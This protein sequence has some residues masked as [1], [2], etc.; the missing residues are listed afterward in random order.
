MSAAPALKLRVRRVEGAPVVS[1]RCAVLGGARLEERPGQALITGR[2]LSEGTRRSSWSEIAEQAE[3]RG[4]NLHSSGSYEAHGL[5]IDALAEDWSP[6]LD[7]LAELLLE[8]TFPEPRCEWLRRQAAAELESLG[9]Q[10]DVLTGWAFAKQLYAPHPRARPV[11]GT[12]SGLAALGAAECVAFHRAGLGR[13]L[14]ISAAGDL[15]EEAV[16]ARAEHLFASA[17]EG[18]PCRSEPASPGEPP[19]PDGREP[20]RRELDVPGDQ[21]H[22]FLGHLSVPKAHPDAIALDVLAVILGAGSGLSGRLPTRI[23][24][25]EGL[26]YSTQ[27]HTLAGA[28]LDPG[29]FVVYVG[30]SPETA[31]Q[32]ETAAREELERLLA[33][34]VGEREVEEAKAYLIGREA[35]RRETARQWAALMIE[36]ELYGRPLD[37]PLWRREQLAAIDREAVES[38]ARRHLRPSELYVTLG[39]NPQAA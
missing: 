3:S 35:F 16:R 7:R 26:A 8:S 1:L 9:D 11:H 13:G 25:R 10:P 21:A 39:R 34:G 5:S 24:E 32:A 37:D 15:D 36:A 31:A 27:V 2:M 4:M 14:L 19:A 12:A 23:R 6:A 38:A 29:R 18:E 33:D 22:L 20:R 17:G 30:T 28:G